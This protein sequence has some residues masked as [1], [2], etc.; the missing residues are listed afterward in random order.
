M[1]QQRGGVGEGRVQ[2]K[3]MVSWGQVTGAVKRS[4]QA[5]TSIFSII[6]PSKMDIFAVC[7]ADIHN[8]A[9][10]YVYVDVNVYIYASTYR[11]A[12]MYADTPTPVYWH[13]YTHMCIVIYVCMYIH[14]HT[15]LDM[16]G[17]P[18]EARLL[19]RDSMASCSAA[20]AADPSLVLPRRPR[21]PLLGH[22]RPPLG[23]G[24]PLL[25][26]PGASTDLAVVSGEPCGTWDETDWSLA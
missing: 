7:S 19:S 25:E 6:A 21:W 17:S 18:E 11:R 20:S 26:L 3:P 1:Q 4:Q 23:F 24:R 16:S 13:M 5:C 12:H 8:N 14:T 2:V 22:G 15:Y 9:S 10:K